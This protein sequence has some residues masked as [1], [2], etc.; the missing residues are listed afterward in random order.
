MVIMRR[1][2][3][4]QARIA[5]NPEYASSES[6][7]ANVIGAITSLNVQFIES[8]PSAGTRVACAIA[9]VAVVSRVTPG[10]AKAATIAPP[11][12]AVA[13]K[14]SDLVPVYF[15]G[16]SYYPYRW[17]GAYYRHRYDRNGGRYW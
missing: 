7:D 8:V 3:W 9:L 10:V 16:G 5:K 1:T 11:P 15:W 4:P 14:G 2:E 17:H 6:V 12:A 13:S